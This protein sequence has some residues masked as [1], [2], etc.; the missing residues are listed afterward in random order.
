MQSCIV[1]PKTLGAESL[2]SHT[3]SSC[4]WSCLL[5]FLSE[6]EVTK[7]GIAQKSSEKSQTSFISENQSCIFFSTLFAVVSAY[8]K[9]NYLYFPNIFKS[10]C[11]QPSDITVILPR[12]YLAVFFLGQLGW[13]L[14]YLFVL[15]MLFFFFFKAT[16]NSAI[17]RKNTIVIPIMVV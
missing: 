14:G 16:G 4:F 7:E 11:I 3:D 17:D 8:S 10:C 15:H 2:Q 5:S 9:L 13:V 1:E 12:K 6:G